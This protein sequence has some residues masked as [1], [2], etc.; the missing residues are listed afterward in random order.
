MGTERISMIDPHRM[1]VAA[2]DNH[3][4]NFKMQNLDKHGHRLIRVCFELV[5]SRG[6]IAVCRLFSVARGAS[7]SVA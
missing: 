3:D 5:D 1:E 4:C 2:A 7:E 6:D